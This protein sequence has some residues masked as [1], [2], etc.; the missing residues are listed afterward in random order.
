MYKKTGLAAF[1]A[2]CWSANPTSNPNAQATMAACNYPDV[3]Q[4]S[5]VSTMRR[6]SLRYSLDCISF[7]RE[8][9]RGN[10]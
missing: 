6:S 2:N 7:R 8:T 1:L 9:V 4:V 5:E 3:N 10:S